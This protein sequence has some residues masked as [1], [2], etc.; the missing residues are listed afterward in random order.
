MME[1][2]PLDR[3]SFQRSNDSVGHHNE[4]NAPTRGIAYGGYHTVATT[5]WQSQ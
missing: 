1:T 3:L 5:Q 2:S 4:A